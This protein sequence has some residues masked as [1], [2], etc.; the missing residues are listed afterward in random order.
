MLA[1]A[2]AYKLTFIDCD[3]LSFDTACLFPLL[4]YKALS[5]SSSSMLDSSKSSYSKRSA[6]L[7][8]LSL[9]LWGF[10]RSA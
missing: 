5:K 6:E 7:E 10:K 4:N 3:F 8:E 1:L 9:L 2:E